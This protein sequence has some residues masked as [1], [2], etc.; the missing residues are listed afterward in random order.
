M[1]TMKRSYGLVIPKSKASAAPSRTVSVFGEDEVITTD[2]SVLHHAQAVKAA[3][4]EIAAQNAQE[5]DYDSWKAGADDVAAKEVEIRKSAHAR[6]VQRSSRY[7]ANLLVKAEDRKRERDV[8]F[9]RL[10]AKEL[11]SDELEAGTSESF[12]TPAYASLLEQRAAEEALEHARASK[13]IH[14]GSSGSMS[15]F[16]LGLTKNVS[17][18]GP[19]LKRARHEFEHSSSLVC[20]QPPVPHAPGISDGLTEAAS[21]L[22]IS[23]AVAEGLGVARVSASSIGLNS[24]CAPLVSVGIASAMKIVQ[25]APPSV[26]VAKKLSEDAISAAKAA[27]LLRFQDRQRGAEV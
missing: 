12:V 10:Q 1:G 26:P 16:Y 22:G 25:H 24:S 15:D 3:Q 21:G 8:I 5:F 20:G 9:D 17:F 19:N 11:A 2:A 4:A 14:V 23:D 13:E 27:A 7:I 6:G 18:G